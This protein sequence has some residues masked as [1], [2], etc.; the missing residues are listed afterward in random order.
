MAVVEIESGLP[1]PQLL[2][3]GMLRE[4]LKRRDMTQPELA[5]L[6]NLSTGY[7]SQLISGRRRGTL[8]TWEIVLD[9]VGCDYFGLTGW[10]LPVRRHRQ[11]VINVPAPG[12]GFKEAR[13]RRSG[14]GAV[15]ENG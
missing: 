8:K 6:S 9:V 2:L 3:I 13:A 5:K 14:V 11:G 12:H 4:G 15:D 10:N 7:V 1:K